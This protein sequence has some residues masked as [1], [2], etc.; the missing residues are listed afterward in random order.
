MV[1][2]RGH[3]AEFEDG[4][5]VDAEDGGR[6]GDGG[7][8][9]LAGAAV[10]EATAFHADDAPGA[11]GDLGGIHRQGARADLGQLGVGRVIEAH[12]ATAEGRIGVAEADVERRRAAGAE[13]FAG[14]GERAPGGRLAA[15]VV[16]GAGSDRQPGEARARVEDAIAETARVDVEVTGENG[17]GIELQDACAGLVDRAGGVDEGLQLQGG[18]E[19]VDVRDAVDV[20][21]ADIDRATRRTEAETT[22]D[23]ADRADIGRSGGDATRADRQDTLGAGTV[24]IEGAE[25]TDGR[26]ARRA[27]VIQD[28]AELGIITEVIERALARDSHVV[29]RRDQAGGEDVHRR[30]ADHEALEGV[31]RRRDVRGALDMERALV[32]EGAAREGIEARDAEHA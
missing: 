1:H 3:V 20:D 23:D 19:R 31:R 11:V 14:T 21:G 27:D 18:A 10:E 12:H 8:E 13:D 2:G 24:S 32:D 9:G 6:R 30:A 7:R 5:V 25:G 28:Q 4:A 26:V 15:E 22:F 16:T 29:R 17:L